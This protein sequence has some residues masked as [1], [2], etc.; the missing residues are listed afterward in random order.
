VLRKIVDFQPH[1]QRDP[2]DFDKLVWT[3]PI[4]EYSDADPLHRDLAAVA[5]R[6][7]TIAAGADLSAADHFTAKRRA[8]RAALAAAGIAEEIEVLVAALLPN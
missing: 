1:G 8:I 5:A 7:E 3:L 2:R 6:A 4:P